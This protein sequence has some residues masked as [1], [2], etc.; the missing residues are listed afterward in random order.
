MVQ[1]DT[2]KDTFYEKHPSCHTPVSQN[3]TNKNITLYPPQIAYHVVFFGKPVSRAW[4]HSLCLQAFLPDEDPN[5]KVSQAENTC[6]H[7]G[8][9]VTYLGSSKIQQPT[10]SRSEGGRQSFS[11]FCRGATNVFKLM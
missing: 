7:D 11:S 6:Q 1:N 2:N 9:L 3:N 5:T 10:G 8:I 4:V